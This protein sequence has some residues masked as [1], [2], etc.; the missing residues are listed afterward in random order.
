MIVILLN[1]SSQCN[2]VAG[3]RTY[4][5]YSLP[6]VP[7]FVCRTKVPL[8]GSSHAWALRAPCNAIILTRDSGAY[9]HFSLR[10]FSVHRLTK[11]ERL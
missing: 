5:R 11:F 8:A 7:R 3:V 1:T 10:G 2:C 9:P 4:P 6:T